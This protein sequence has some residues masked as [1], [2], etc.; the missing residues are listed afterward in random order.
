VWIIMHGTNRN[1]ATYRNYFL[2]SA[3]AYGALVI[4]P[5]FD[6]TNWAGSS[7]YNLGN[8]SV[9]ETNLTP[10]AERDWSFSKIE[11]LFD[12]VVNALEP[13]IDVPR[14][15]MF[16]HSAGSQFVH[17]F[18][19]W[20]PNARVNMAVAANAGWYT[21]AQFADAGYPYNWPYTLTN[22]PDIDTATPGV[23][24][25]PAANLETALGNRMIVLLGNQDL[26]RDSDLRV[27]VEADAQ[28]LHRY[29]RGQY[30]FAEA[31]AEAAARG[32]PFG[33]D[34]QIVPGV[35]HS[36]SQMAIPAAQ[37]FRFAETMP[38]DFDANGVVD[39]TDYMIWTQD[40]G[41]DMT[42]GIG[43]DANHDGKV[44]A[45][46]YTI[47]RD[48]LGAV[49][50]AGSASAAVGRPLPT[51]EPSSIALATII[52]ACLG[53]AGRRRLNRPPSAPGRMG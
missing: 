14:Y 3:A 23:Q 51:P 37:L 48:N 20:K 27:T 53:I 29:A 24:P 9:S 15:S 49:V 41:K 28:G 34:M 12:H 36:G 5:T 40:F 39:M 11:P 45:A 22:T 33:W 47:W 19:M 10:R 7:G 8:I 21:M 6:D 52:A 32:V 4:A 50:G 30:F 1:A 2:T 31:E 38:G 18:M 43:A 16:G 46:D 26:V 25:F 44:D 13:V 42:K 35:G 17:R